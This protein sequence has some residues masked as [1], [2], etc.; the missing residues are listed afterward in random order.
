MWLMFIT[1]NVLITLSLT[2]KIITLLRKIL[3][4]VH[5]WMMWGEDSPIANT[6]NCPI[7]NIQNSTGVGASIRSC[8]FTGIWWRNIYFCK[9]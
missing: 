8:W 5:S 6:V 1:F 4:I 9:I 7:M 2:F 3:Y